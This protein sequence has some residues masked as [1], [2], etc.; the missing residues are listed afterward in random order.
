M[1][2]CEE[3]QVT[4]KS[5]R[6]HTEQG[7]C[8]SWLVSVQVCLSGS[9]L[10]LRET[11]EDCQVTSDRSDLTITCLGLANCSTMVYSIQEGEARDDLEDVRVGVVVTPLYHPTVTTMYRLDTRLADLVGR[12]VLAH[13]KYA[14]T[15]IHGYARANKLYH[16]KTIKCDE[17][18]YSIFER[19]IIELGTLWK[20][21]CRKIKKV[22][23]G[24]VSV[25]HKMSTLEKC[26]SSEMRVSVDNDYNIY[27]EDWKLEINRGSKS[28]LKTQSFLSN[29]SNSKDK[30]KSFKRNKSF[31]L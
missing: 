25:S 5:E 31:E 15:I 29:V 7:D 9:P 18:L 16:Q 20:E 13:P 30:R 1:L 3:F 2:R 17:L 12:K 19:D 14:L 8:R 22:E 27:P 6:E 28:F 11:L 4:V 24:V 23:R 10:E 26:S 21:I